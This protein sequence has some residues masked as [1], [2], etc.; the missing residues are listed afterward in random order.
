MKMGFWSDRALRDDESKKND[1]GLL[2]T[3]ALALKDKVS[4]KVDEF[5]ELE[6]GAVDEDDFG[7]V[8]EVG[9]GDYRDDNDV[10]IDIAPAQKAKSFHEFLLANKYH[11]LELLIRGYKKVWNKDKE[12]WE[13]KRKK[14]HCFDDE[15]AETIVRILETHLSPDIK[16]SYISIN[17]YPIKMLAIKEQ[18]E[19][20]FYD[21]ADYK[22][23]RYGNSKIQYFMKQD[24]FAIFVA[25]MERITANYSMAIKG[26]E[27]KYTHNSVRSQESLQQDD[28]S[29]FDRFK[30][31]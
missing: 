30:N 29:N 11:D 15:E 5:M 10:N 2:K 20:Y 21:I 3:N 7:G 19:G 6:E 25:V 26:Q 8:D 18:L 22:Y 13:N 12:E 17:N 4:E 23:G 24:N 31:Y 27:N 28:T 1:M 14:S 9:K 16:L